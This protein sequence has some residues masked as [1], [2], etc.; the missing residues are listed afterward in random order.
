MND[1][2]KITI[3][4]S[5]VAVLSFIMGVFLTYTSMKACWEKKAVR[6]GAAHYDVKTGEFTWNSER[7]TP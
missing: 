3:G 2:T 5:A 4:L 6:Y 1:D 7:K